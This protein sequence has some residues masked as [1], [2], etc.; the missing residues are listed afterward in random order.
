MSD[1]PS[2]S[3]DRP[4]RWWQVQRTNGDADSVAADRYAMA[5]D[6]ICF[7]RSDGELSQR[8]QAA[9]V[10]HATRPDNP[11]MP[12]S[13]WW[14]MERVN[15]DVISVVA[16]QHRLAGDWIE[17]LRADGE[18]V[19]CLRAADVARIEHLKRPTPSRR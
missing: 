15:G 11:A 13:S 7:Y 3:P 12:I 14:Q 8:I 18:V 4:G 5:D 16:A 10:S 17:F 9:V 2:S 1:R 6:W 19:Q